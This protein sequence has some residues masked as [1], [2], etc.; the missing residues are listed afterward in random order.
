VVT[1]GQQLGKNLTMTEP[2]TPESKTIG[3]NEPCPCGSGKK[4]KRCCGVSA[5][6]KLTV[7][8]QA[9]GAPGGGWDPAALGNMDPQMMAQFS[10][11]LQR[12]PKSQLQRL[13]V[14]MQKAMSGKDVSAEAAEFEKTLPP[15]FQQ[16]M[17]AWGMAAA[18]SMSETSPEASD[19]DTSEMTEEKAR[20]IV[21]RAAAEGAITKDK[22]E[23]LL[24]NFKQD[25]LPSLPEVLPA[26]ENLGE[27]DKDAPSKFGKF[28]KNLSGKKET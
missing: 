15:D 9:V 21:A 13:Q 14:M 27:P 1:N 7:P 18:A 24:G 22:A 5:A 28:W 12:L 19:T 26:V 23:S 17:Q 16:M 4:Y 2:Q 10:Q 11:A 6:P 3:R 25:A 8:K 20:E